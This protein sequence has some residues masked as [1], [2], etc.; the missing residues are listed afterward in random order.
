MSN[1][2]LDQLLRK[3]LV[4]PASPLALDLTHTQ[5]VGPGYGIVAP[6]ALKS[7]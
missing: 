4:I 6:L 2:N 7:A 1:P 3:G 5:P